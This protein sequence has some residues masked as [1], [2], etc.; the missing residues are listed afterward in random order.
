MPGK[1]GYC[2]GSPPPYMPSIPPAPGTDHS[3]DPPPPASPSRP[4]SCAGKSIAGDATLHN[5]HT[6]T[7]THTPIQS[8][9]YKGWQHLLP[10]TTRVLATL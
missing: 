8:A 9:L 1:L 3:P 10:S 7:R 4:L 5:T 6:N 2:K